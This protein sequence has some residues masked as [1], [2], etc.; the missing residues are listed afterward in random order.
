M[1]LTLDH[2]NDDGGKRAD[3]RKEGGYSFYKKLKRLEYPQNLGL[4]TLC[5]NCNCGRARN[6]GICPHK[7]A[8][9]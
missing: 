9:C 5:W 2:S 8:K 6:G 3:G 4:R 1:F 7:E